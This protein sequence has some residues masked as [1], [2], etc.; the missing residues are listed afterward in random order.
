MKLVLKGRFPSLNEVI[1]ITKGH[2]SQYSKMKKEL[3]I[4]VALEA[5]VQRMKPVKGGKVK[6]VFH[7]YEKDWRRDVDGICGWAQKPILDGLVE[8]GVLPTD[9]RK[10]C[11][12]ELDHV[13]PDPDKDNPRVVVEIVELIGC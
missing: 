7:W 12:A 6:V 10:N 9:G 1:A 4:S 13:F 2:W 8:A 11:V 3:T 5:R